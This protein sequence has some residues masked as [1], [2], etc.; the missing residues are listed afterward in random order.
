MPGI[1]HNFVFALAA[2]P[3]TKFLRKI[4]YFARLDFDKHLIARGYFRPLFADDDDAE[5]RLFRSLDHFV[6]V[7]DDHIRSGFS[8][9]RGSPGVVVVVRCAD[10]GSSAEHHRHR[11]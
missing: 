4:R 3:L 11:L 1:G 10:H 7:G 2:S 5:E 6:G 8:R 9:S